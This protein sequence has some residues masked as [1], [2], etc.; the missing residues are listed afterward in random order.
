MCSTSES[1]DWAN[2]AMASVA[3]RHPRTEDWVQALGARLLV[4]GDLLR[5]GRIPPVQDDQLGAGRL[6][7]DAPVE[8]QIAVGG[9]VKASS[10]SGSFSSVT[11][12]RSCLASRYVRI[13]RLRAQ[14]DQ[15]ASIWAG[16]FAGHV[17]EQL[18]EP[19]ARARSGARPPS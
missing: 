15:R 6:A 1:P 2:Q 4:D 19:F 17:P 3:D 16:V 9:A 10:S 14:V 7:L 5:R 12:G 18:H 11:S 8:E 13:T